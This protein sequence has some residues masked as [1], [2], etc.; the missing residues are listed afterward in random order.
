VA[1]S[2]GDWEFPRIGSNHQDYELGD[3]AKN[4]LLHPSLDDQN[5]LRVLSQTYFKKQLFSSDF[6]DNVA[7]KNALENT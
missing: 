6:A 4:R 7:G 3:L 1:P 5:D 2:E